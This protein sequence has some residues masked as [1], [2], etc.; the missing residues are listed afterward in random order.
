MKKGFTLIEL[1][2]V[3]IILA[4]LCM[5][6]IPP[7]LNS[8]NSTKNELSEVAKELIMNANELY[9]SDNKLNYPE[10]EG[11]TYCLTIKNLIDREYLSSPVLDPIT[12]K[13]V[14]QDKYIKS[15]IHAGVY[16]YEFVDTCEEIRKGDSNLISLLKKQYHVDNKEG[17]L[18]DSEYY[19]KGNNQAV[20]NNYVWYGGFLWRVL[21]FSDTT[22]T[23][24]LISEETLVDIATSSENKIEYTTDQLSMLYS[25]PQSLNFMSTKKDLSFVEEGFYISSRVSKTWL[26]NKSVYDNS[27]LN[28]WLNSEKEDGVFYKNLANSFKD[29][30]IPEK[31]CIG[32]YTNPCSLKTDLLP[33]GLLNEEEY[34][35]AGGNN[36]FLIIYDHWRLGNPVD[37]NLLRTIYF[38]N[39]ASVSYPPVGKD[40][41][42]ETT[43][44][45]G[46][47]PVVTIKDINIAK[48]DGSLHN[49]YR[50]NQIS[51][52][53]NNLASGEYINIP[54]VDGNTKLARVIG[55]EQG[56]IKVVQMTTEDA[57]FVSPAETLGAISATFKEN[58]TPSQLATIFNQ[59]D[60]YYLSDTTK[61][62]NA[63]FYILG[64]NYNSVKIAKNN[65]KIGLQTIGELFSA[66]HTM[67]IDNNGYIFT[68]NGYMN[69][70]GA[71]NLLGTVGPIENVQPDESKPPYKAL[72]CENEGSG[73]ITTQI[74]KTNPTFFIKEDI[75]II[76]GEG[77][78][79]NPYNL[80]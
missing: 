48:G 24:K 28:T 32:I 38:N 19:Y 52:L 72:F 25:Y 66:N 46:I 77:T 56:A 51:Q 29:N 11:N 4:L 73:I 27:Y 80:K 44:E 68:N 42:S 78:K 15:S 60:S 2:G 61:D 36:S 57:S 23:L 53:T 63:G 67:L 35:K 39:S 70:C 7:I 12:K 50:T 21:S 1:I 14:S 54:K 37:S 65:S 17:L 40:T 55:H 31:F 10:V 74:H 26:N 34:T 62:F 47:R 16:T 45:F 33:V 8:I 18:K 75:K 49:P 13:E 9:L 22:N 79:E 6:A 69:V 71:Y 41:N 5:L 64:G 3:I 20:S 43:K 76:S 58:Q 30:I 59:F